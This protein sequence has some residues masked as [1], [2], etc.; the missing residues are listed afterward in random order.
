MLT[1]S[2]FRS[3]LLSSSITSCVSLTSSVPRSVGSVCVSARAGR[4]ATDRAATDRAATRASAS[5]MEP[6]PSRD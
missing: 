4:A 6:G 5:I 3:A 2:T 1:N